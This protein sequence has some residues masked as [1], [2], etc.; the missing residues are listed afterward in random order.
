MNDGGPAMTLVTLPLITRHRPTQFTEVC[1]NAAAVGSL[2]R[3]IGQPG[4]PHAYLFTGP[5]GTGK[6][7]LARIVGTVLNTDIFEV[8]AASNN[9]VDAM[10][11]LVDS[12][13]YLAPGAEGR[14]IILD[15]VHRLSRNSWDILLK[16]LE[17]P[18]AHLYIAL[19]T[20]ELYRIPNT[21]V[22]RCYHVAL[23]QLATREIEDFVLDIMDREGWVDLVQPDVFHLIVNEANGSP[24]LALTLLQEAYDAP[25]E[26]EARRI[27]AIQGSDSPLIQILTILMSG[28]GGW[29]SIRPMLAQLSDDDFA[30]SEIVRASRYLIGALSREE[31]EG[32]AQRMW[33]VLADLTYPA[34]SYDP[35]SLFVA[36]VGRAL[37]GGL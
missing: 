1:G 27:I 12:G 37:W 6:T 20:T 9:G 13:Y 19:C 32:K 36:A 23:K 2:A 34:H 14:T 4:Q 22:T 25:N 3:R 33:R 24:R 7:T 29:D 15:E 26:A 28:Q 35:K 10:R 30:E 8:D 21:I 11:A 17:E 31:S 5:S 18:P 16:V